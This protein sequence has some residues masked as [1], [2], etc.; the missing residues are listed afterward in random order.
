MTAAAVEWLR[1]RQDDQPFFLWVHY[2]DPHATHVPPEEYATPFF[3]DEFYDS[4]PLRLNEDDN[5]FDSGVAGR[6]WRQN[7]SQTEHGWY[8]ANYD[9][10]IAYTDAMIGRL[11]DT[12]DRDG[13]L[14]NS[15]VILTADH[16]ESLG[17]HRYF[18]GSSHESVRVERV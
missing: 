2:V 12:I 14:S 1:A 16:G 10:E 9:G 6:Y 11:L 18:F 4:T 3:E 15:L 7:D 13:F 5:N 8:I 17:E